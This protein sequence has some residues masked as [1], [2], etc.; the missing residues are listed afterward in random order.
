MR[1]GRQRAKS[2]ARL[3]NSVDFIIQGGSGTGKSR[4]GALMP[5]PLIVHFERQGLATCLEWNPD[6]IVVPVYEDDDDGTYTG[7]PNKPITSAK[8]RMT[9]LAHQLEA[10]RASVPVEGGG[11]RLRD[12]D[13]CKKT[14]S[15]LRFHDPT[16]DDPIIESFVVDSA[17]EAQRVMLE[18]LTGRDVGDVDDKEI[19]GKT[20]G[21]LKDTTIGLF[22]K[23]RD[24]P[25]YTMVLGLSED[26]DTGDGIKA[27]PSFFGKKVG[28]AVAQFVNAVGWIKKVSDGDGVRWACVFEGATNVALTKGCAGLEAIEQLPM[29]PNDGSPQIWIAKIQAEQKRRADE[30]GMREA[31]AVPSEDET[32]SGAAPATKET[33]GGEA[34]KPVSLEDVGGKAATGDGKAKPITP[35]DLKKAP[36]KPAAS[37]D[38]PKGGRGGRGGRGRK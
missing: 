36:P 22:R 30:L 3:N 32:E 33:I 1:Y 20:W 5:R 11:R 16:D 15:I 12:Y 37:G 2:V 7:T 19:G 4:L 28:P 34:G 29:D 10:I 26:T 23:I 21:R 31:P 13:I 27:I 9:I 18:A 6:A 35:D 24:L 25:V 38:A 14:L 8:L 17:T